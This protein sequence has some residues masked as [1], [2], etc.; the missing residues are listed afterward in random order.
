MNRSTSTFLC[1][2]TAVLTA[3][4]LVCCHHDAAHAQDWNQF[5]GNG[6][7]ATTTTAELPLEWDDETNIQW[8][9]ELPG[10]GAS[11]PIIVGD[12]VFLTCYSGYGDK[13]KGKIENLVR[14]I[15]CF[16]RT[17]GKIIWQKS[18][19]NSEVKDEDPYKSFITQHGY[20]TNTPVSDGKSVFVFLGKPGLFAY[21]LDGNEL[22]KKDIS[23]KTNKTRW[24]SASSPILFGDNLIL[25]AIEEC[26]KVF[27]ISKSD[28]EIN[29]EFDAKSKLAY[30]TPTLVTNAE[31]EVEL[32]LPVPNRVIGLNPVDG[33]QKWFATNKF[34]NESNASVLVDKDIIYIYGGF[35]SVGSMAM[36]VGGMGDVT[37]SHVLWNTRDTSYVSTPI[38]KDGHLYWIDESGIAFCVKAESGEQVYKKRVPGVRG[39]RGIKFFASMIA[40]GDNMYAVSRRSG[41]F[42]IKT[43]PEYELVSHNKISA[44]DSEFNGSPAVSQN[45]LIIRS[46]RFLY[47]IG[48]Q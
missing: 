15:F 1:N 37:K 19:D 10:P 42:V 27:S 25:N 29:W 28:G 23:Y 4:L 40:A 35:R 39:G 13:P 7:T 41:T 26:G 31:G 30:A 20:A 43:K 38:L 32:V 22:W 34:D 14:H 46:N 3:L 9:T 6:G 47:C 8:K 11:S 45:Q 48:Q 33:T 16:N 21:D 17:D 36:R 2:T 24:G 44:D 12:R 18:I 5:L